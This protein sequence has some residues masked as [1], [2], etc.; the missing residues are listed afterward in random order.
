MRLRFIALLAVAPGALAVASPAA[1][2]A[3]EVSYT[4]DG[5]EPNTESEK[6]KLVKK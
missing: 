4:P 6:L 2:P 5:G 3:A 1:A